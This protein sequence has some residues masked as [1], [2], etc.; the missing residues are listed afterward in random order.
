[1]GVPQCPPPVEPSPDGP[2]AAL[3]P[4]AIDG[5]GVKLLFAVFALAREVG[6]G[7]HLTVEEVVQQRECHLLSRAAVGA[8][9]QHVGGDD[10]AAHPHLRV[11]LVPQP[12]AVGVILWKTEGS[13]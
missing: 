8:D 10:G 7:L 5:Q 13:G 6:D 3:T 4:D 12:R 1:M 11:V 2:E 9:V